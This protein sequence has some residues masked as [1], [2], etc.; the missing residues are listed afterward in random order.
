MAINYCKNGLVYAGQY[1]KNVKSTKFFWCENNK[2]KY[3]AKTKFEGIINCPLI[4]ILSDQYEAI[5]IQC[6]LNKLFIEEGYQSIG[7][8]DYPFAYLYGLEYIDTQDVSVSIL[9]HLYE[10]YCPDIMILNLQKGSLQHMANESDF[11]IFLQKSREMKS[12]TSMPINNLNY[13]ELIGNVE[14]MDI[15]FLYD[16]IIHYFGV[17]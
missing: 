9:A 12:K 16:K 14:E 2:Y 8:S 13:V 1:N 11:F 7:I 6:K 10:I 3:V 5:A 17:Q 4:V 15:H